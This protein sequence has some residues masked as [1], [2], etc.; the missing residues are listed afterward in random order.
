ML[1]L[2]GRQ[3]KEAV[4]AQGGQ[5]P[6]SSSSLSS[7]SLSAL[8]DARPQWGAPCFTQRTCSNAGLFQT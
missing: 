2:E 3:G 1:A 8:D 7:S 4:P 6:F 5:M